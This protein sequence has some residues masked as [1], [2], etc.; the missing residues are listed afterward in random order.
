MKKIFAFIAVA[1]GLNS[2]GLLPTSR[3]IICNGP[4]QEVTMDKFKNFT[5]VT[6]DGSAN[7][8]FKQADRYNVSVRA[9]QEVFDHIDYR[10]SGKNLV[11]GTERLVTL[12]PEVYDVFVQAPWFTSI[13]V[14]GSADIWMTEGYVSSTNLA[15]VVNGISNIDFIGVSVPTLDVELNG[16]ARI[17]LTDIFVDKLYINL[18]GTGSVEISGS[19]DYASITISGAASVDATQL[20]CARLD[21]NITGT[22]TIK[23]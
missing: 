14:N 6:I 4:V 22:G 5:D 11:I 9:N 15:V 23:L 20:E 12:V 10:L 8:T 16:T 2:C 17:F 1:I 18:S 3:T 21:K 13:I 7:V 19:A